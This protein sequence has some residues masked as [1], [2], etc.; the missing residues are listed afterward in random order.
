MQETTETDNILPDSTVAFP[1][2]G[3]LDTSDTLGIR[4]LNLSQVLDNPLV[5]SQEVVQG[6]Q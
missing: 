3:L 6:T 2:L 1:G 4:R 5:T